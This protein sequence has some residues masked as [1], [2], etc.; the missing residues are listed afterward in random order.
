MAPSGWTLRPGAPMHEARR[1]DRRR[2]LFSRVAGD[3]RLA[4]RTYFFLPQ[5]AMI[6]TGRKPPFLMMLT[7]P[8]CTPLISS[9]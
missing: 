2:A 9:A 6:I 3:R 1:G 7:A 4:P 5:F 8:I